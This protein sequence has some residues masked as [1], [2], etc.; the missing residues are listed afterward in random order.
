[1]AQGGVVMWD[2]EK[3]ERF[4]DKLWIA[5]EIVFSLMVIGGIVA[6]YLIYR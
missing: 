4:I 5:Y 2:R 6:D 1:M 3:V